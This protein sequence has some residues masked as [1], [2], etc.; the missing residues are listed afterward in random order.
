MARHEVQ[1]RERREYKMFE[2]EFLRH[3][4][5]WKTLGLL[6]FALSGCAS[7]HYRYGRFNQSAVPFS[8]IQRP[9]VEQGGV[10]PNLDRVERLLHAPGRKLSKWF[11]EPYDPVREK[12][13]QDQTL[14]T[15]L[16]YLADHD[17]NDVHVE[18]RRY[19]PWEQWRRLRSNT[20]MSPIFKYTDGAARVLSGTLLPNRVFH[21]DSY[22][23]YTNTLSI[24][25][26][27]PS[28]ALIES[29][30]SRY[31]H[32]ARYPGWRAASQNLPMMSVYHQSQIAS[33]ALSYVQA[34][35]DWPLERE[36]YPTAYG[37]I[38]SSVFLEGY[39]LN[40]ATGPA[41]LIAGPVASMVGS[42]VGTG[43]GNVAVQQREKERRP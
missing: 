5:W 39:A 36:L 18:V 15:S 22:N 7:D 25:S 20:R 40:P 14:A 4:A 35:R 17:L 12:Q 23:P 37:S 21:S 42:T 30:A 43:I 24:N 6:A 29:A 8:S 10:H 27:S 1:G 38:G 34:K 11:G 19:A 41:G 31:S 28:S 16:S 13:K 3:H 32:S 2:R 26:D 33:E 9:I